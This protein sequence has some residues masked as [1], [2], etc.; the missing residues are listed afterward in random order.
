[1]WYII[2]MNWLFTFIRLLIRVPISASVRLKAASEY[3]NAVWLLLWDMY[4]WSNWLVAVGWLHWCTSSDVWCWNLLEILGRD[5]QLVPSVVL[6]VPIWIICLYAEIRGWVRSC[7]I[8]RYLYRSARHIGDSISWDRGRR[9]INVFLF[10][11]PVQIRAVVD[12][13]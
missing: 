9:S 1:M 2:K 4:R 7:T 6:L 11:I 8:R 10:H 3:E 13:D 12:E 5:G